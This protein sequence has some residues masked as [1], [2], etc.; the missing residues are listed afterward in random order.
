MERTVVCRIVDY[1][2][3]TTSLS[4]LHQHTAIFYM[5]YSTTVVLVLS[6]PLLVWTDVQSVDTAPVSMYQKMPGVLSEQ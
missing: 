4:F 1:D 5:L 3:T 2:Q 6:A